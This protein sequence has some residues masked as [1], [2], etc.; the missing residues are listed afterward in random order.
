MKQRT[1]Y[2][3][4]LLTIVQYAFSRPV[5]AHPSPIVKSML[6][7]PMQDQHVH[8]SS[9][10]CLPDG[11][12]LAAWFQGSGERKADDVKI[13]GA[14]LQKGKKNWSKPFLMADT[15]HIPDCNPVLFLNNGGKLF[16]VWIAVQANRWENS[17]LRYRTSVDY[18]KSGTPV[19]DWQD[20]ILLKPDDRFAEEV[21]SKFKQLTPNTSG[22]SAYAPS[23]DDMIIAAGRDAGKR[24]FGWMTRIHPLV[25]KN[26]RILLPL[27]SDGFNFSLA[28]VSDDDGS[29]WLPSLPIVGRGNVQPSLAQ[30]KDGTVVAYM[31]DNGDAPG[32]V[33][34][35]TSTDQGESWTA[36]RKTK[37]PNTASVEVC[38]L[39]DGKWA[40]VG[41]DESD[42]RYR[43]SL[44]LSDDEGN[45][46]KWKMPLEN[47]PKGEGSFSYPSMI[48]APDGLLH[49]TYSYQIGDH[50][51]SI[52]Y[53][54]VNPE[55]IVQQNMGT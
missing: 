55:M 51:E 33:Q 45:T 8:G 18:E 2:V 12:F 46:W 44:Y 14:R 40:F 3:L 21:A 1:F 27:Y 23:Y 19:W 38:T 43:L 36:A 20:D 24:S 50:R 42:G 28:A 49:I 25:L 15:Y 41:N 22:W 7:F 26:G 6:I 54:V 4:L 35:S 53:I 47:V 5:P 34:I 52:K 16:L 31:R 9:I 32:R 13:M 39:Q 37:I 17:I 48:Q 11:D 29:T 10:V 30:K